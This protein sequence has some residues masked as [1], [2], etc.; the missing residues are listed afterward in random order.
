M[1]EYAI[2]ALI[3]V[4][5]GSLPCALFGYLIAVKQKRDL[6][7]GWDESKV[8]NPQAFASLVGWSL[9][10]TSGPLAGVAGAWAAKWLSETQFT[11][12]LIVVSLPPVI[13]VFVAKA[14]YGR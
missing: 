10:L 2:A 1:D 5:A 7:S 12:A 13:A 11:V 4:L 8:R 6:I 14:K 3:I 9:I